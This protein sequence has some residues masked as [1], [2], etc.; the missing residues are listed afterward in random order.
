M[1]RRER[2]F[3]TGEITYSLG[4][5]FFGNLAAK[6]TG[7]TAKKLATKMAE[8]GVEKIGE[9]TGEMI[10][11]KIYNKF[12]KKPVT[13]MK[14]EEIVKL[15]KNAEGKRSELSGAKRPISVCKRYL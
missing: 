6:I 4:S 12:T 10:G 7:K 14:G 15:L 8:K 13:E 1:E 11:E 3:D 2:N 9:K 5:G